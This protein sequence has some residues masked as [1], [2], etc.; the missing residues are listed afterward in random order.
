MLCFYPR[1]VEQ[2]LAISSLNRRYSRQR[3]NFPPNNDEEK[4]GKSFS[5]SE[6]SLFTVDSSFCEAGNWLSV[7]TLENGFLE[8]KVNGGV[9]LMSRSHIR[10]QRDSSWEKQ[11]FASFFLSLNA[12]LD[13]LY[14]NGP[15]EAISRR[16]MCRFWSAGPYRT[17]HSLSRSVSRGNW[18]VV[19]WNVAVVY[20]A[21]SNVYNANFI[22]HPP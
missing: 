22:L 4:G 19:M 3:K 20:H 21:T 5:G 13:V 17:S 18:D 12:T 2:A 6:K 8:S 14:L 16:C 10:V 15:K 9:D 11:L 7:C 1:R